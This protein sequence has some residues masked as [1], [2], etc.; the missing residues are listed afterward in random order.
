[1]RA[2]PA[3]QSSSPRDARSALAAPQG[4]KRAATSKNAPPPK[5]HFGH[6]T[7]CIQPRHREGV[8]E[9][10]LHPPPGARSPRPVPHS[11]PAQRVRAIQLSVTSLAGRTELRCACGAASGAPANSMALGAPAGAVAAPDPVWRHGSVDERR[12][13]PVY[14]HELSI[15][16]NV[17]NS[18]PS[19]RILPVLCPNM[20]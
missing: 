1:M 14:L 9:V 7:H 2:T 4:E 8:P 5:R 6:S 16:E 13:P 10:S 20:L 18:A 12:L 19:R 3:Q 17:A 15:K 11:P